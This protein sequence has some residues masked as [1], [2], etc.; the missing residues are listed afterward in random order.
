MAPKKRPAAAEDEGSAK[1]E[2]AAA[3][4]GEG[5]AAQDAKQDP[6][7]EARS[8]A[9]AVAR[10]QRVVG[11][12]MAEKD[13]LM[14]KLKAN[15]DATKKAEQE[16]ECLREA[17][18]KRAA[19]A[20]RVRSA[21]QKAQREK[22]AAR[23]ATKQ[24]RAHAALKASKKRLD[25][26]RGA[27]S[28]ARGKAE[29]ATDA[30]KRATQAFEQA[31]KRCKE[32]R[33][34]G[35]HVPEEGEKDLSAPGAW[36]PP[37]LQAAKARD[38]AK[39]VLVRMKA[40]W[41]K[42]QAVFDA[43]EARQKAIKEKM[44]A[45]KTSQ[46]V[47]EDGAPA[48]V[49]KRLGLLEG[50]GGVHRKD[51]SPNAAHGAQGNGPGGSAELPVSV[52]VGRAADWAA[53]GQLGETDLLVLDHRGARYHEDL[54]AMEPRLAPGARVLADNVLSPGA[55]LFLPYVQGRY[56]VAIYEVDEFLRPGRTD[57][58]VLCRSRGREALLRDPWP[59][60]P[61]LH[62]WSAEIDEVCFQSCSIGATSEGRRGHV[63]A[64]AWLELQ[65]GLE[66]ENSIPKATAA[67]QR[68]P[69]AAAPG[70]TPVG[71][72]AAV[73]AA[74]AVGA[75]LRAAKPQQTLAGSGGALA[76]PPAELCAAGVEAARQA[77]RRALL[78]GAGAGAP[79][80]PKGEKRKAP[81]Q[82][83]TSEA[84]RWAR[85]K[86]LAPP[87]GPKRVEDNYDIS[88]TEE[89]LN[90]NRVEPDRTGKH[91]PS[92]S[93]NYL[94]AVQAQASLDPD[95]I[96]GTRV[97]QCDLEA[98][99]PDRFYRMGFN[100]VKKRRRGSSGAWAPDALGRQEIKTYAARMGHTRRFSTVAGAFAQRIRGR[101]PKGA[102]ASCDAARADR[103]GGA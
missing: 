75:V 53:S 61:E 98:I 80:A 68:A 50:S 60:P 2:A 9:Q 37:G 18:R 26:M 79:A 97:P 67:P 78:P 6:S 92:W 94:Q 1:G 25:G 103:K 41:E 52:R 5:A 43:K 3:A 81:E 36:K 35:E 74:A 28:A 30:Y 85:V 45:V 10:Q 29:A 88:D 22:Q 13:A 7:K 11:K 93:T 71:L 72:L 65:R 73:W 70:V 69:A 20:G 24:A 14:A 44:Q 21:K 4:A 91:V 33:E 59:A 77:A 83:E 38:A 96:F 99:F 40:A 34:S 84:S 47:T 42:A 63:G 17:A 95:S 15:K 89:D 19:A 31:K 55:P 54:A 51:P 23:A 12:L 46:L 48:K 16:L 56:D 102:P 86:S 58:M 64:P 87:V 49:A 66:P 101:P 76:P 100:P 57:W 32:L 39:V 27:L 62:Q 8:A 82:P 90:G